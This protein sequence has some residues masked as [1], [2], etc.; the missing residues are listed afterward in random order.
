MKILFFSDYFIPEIG[1]PAA[2]VYD[3]CKIWVEQGHEV[4]VI[5]NNPNYP[6]GI[7]YDGF[8][9]RIRRWENIEGI[10][11]LRIWTYPAENRGTLRRKK[12]RNIVQSSS[13][14][15]TNLDLSSRKSWYLQKNFGLYFLLSFVFYKFNFYKKT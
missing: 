10:N 2:H 6:S 15:T 5:T 13:E 11:V 8:S 7:I 14:G 1:A 9:N 4:T 12:V 3:R